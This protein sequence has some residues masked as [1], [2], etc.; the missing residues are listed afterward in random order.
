MKKNASLLAVVIVIMILI[1]LTI[2]TQVT[3]SHNGISLD[4]LESKAD[5]YSTEIID[6]ED[7]PIPNGVNPIELFISSVIDFLF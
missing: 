7:D 1:N 5:G 4:K 6:P 2:S 3:N